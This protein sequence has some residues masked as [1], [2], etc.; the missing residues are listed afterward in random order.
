ML[1]AFFDLIHELGDLGKGNYRLTHILG[2][3]RFPCPAMSM[4][5]SRL[6]P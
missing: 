1:F 5:C 2:F 6:P 3:V 4:N